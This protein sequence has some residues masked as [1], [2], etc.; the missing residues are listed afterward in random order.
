MMTSVDRRVTGGIDTHDDVHVAAVNP[1]GLAPSLRAGRLALP[2]DLRK[3]CLRGVLS[4]GAGGNRTPSPVCVSHLVKA[5]LPCPGYVFG[6]PPVT[7][8]D[9]EW[10]AVDALLT[11]CRPFSALADVSESAGWTGCD[12]GFGGDRCVV[13]PVERSVTRSVR[14]P[15]DLLLASMMLR[16]RSSAGQLAWR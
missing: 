3:G 8:S 4:C 1:K 9:L 12:Q 5:Y 15:H 7:A 10:P 6:C 16:R 13:G 11:P 14:F 2:E